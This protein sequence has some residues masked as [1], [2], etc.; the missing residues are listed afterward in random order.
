METTKKG[1]LDFKDHYYG[2]L[3]SLKDLL[4]CQPR[5][6]PIDADQV[7]LQFGSQDI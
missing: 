1:Q 2:L 4:D 6:S 5:I 3:C 7:I